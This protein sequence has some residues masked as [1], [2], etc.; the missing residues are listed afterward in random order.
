MGP[1]I[2]I[3]NPL[4]IGVISFLGML[5]YEEMWRGGEVSHDNVSISN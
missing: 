1:V 5:D 4:C 3:E 2:I